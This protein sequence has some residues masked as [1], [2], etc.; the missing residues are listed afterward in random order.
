[1]SAR[2]TA[3][4]ALV[5]RITAALSTRMPPPQVQRNV[6]IP[7]ALPSGGLIVVRDGE[8]IDQTTIMSPLSY[9]IEHAAEIEIVARTQATLDTLM[10]AVAAAVVADRTLSGAVEWAA[11]SAP[12]FDDVTFDG[13]APA[14]SASFTVSLFFT[15]AATPLS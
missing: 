3:I 8:I 1:M 14:R 10:T 7:Q 6:T 12:L 11:P 4:S 5:T 9:A 13:A 2:E 15:V